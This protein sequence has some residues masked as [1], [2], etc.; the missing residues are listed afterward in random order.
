MQH[1]DHVVDVVVEIEAAFRHR[2]HARID[3]VGDVDVVVRQEGFDRAAQQRRVVAR[4]RRDDQ[5]LRLRP[6]RGMREAC[7]RNAAAGR[8]AAP[9]SSDVDRHALA[10][11]FGGIDAPFRLAV[12]ARRALEQFAAAA[13]VLPRSVCATD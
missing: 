11:D 1:L 13:I 3:P 8:T 7:A 6:L 10:A 2:H 12:A 9:R 4:H 5:Q